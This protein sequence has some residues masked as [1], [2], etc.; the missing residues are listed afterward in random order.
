M[1]SMS[2]DCV[3]LLIDQEADD[4]MTTIGSLRTLQKAQGCFSG[5]CAAY[6]DGVVPFKTRRERAVRVES[7][8]PGAIAVA[9]SRVATFAGF[10]D[11]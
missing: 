10:H 8:T 4:G 6:Q 5:L 2:S 11:T 3:Y 9:T 7:L 1:P